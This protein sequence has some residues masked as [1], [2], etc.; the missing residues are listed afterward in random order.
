[1]AKRRKLTAPSAEDLQAMDAEFR[2]ETP[3]R[4]NKGSAPIAQVAADSAQLGSVDSA[5][6][7][8]DRLDA[9]RLRDAEKQGLIVT[10]I[11]TDKIHT[12]AMIRDRMVLHEEELLELQYSIAANGL[13]LPIEV[14]ADGDGYALLSGYRRLM[15]MR[16]L[17]EVNGHERHTTIK[18]F[19]RPATDTATSF[20]AMVEENEVR[21]NLSHFERG[22]IAVIAA[23][24]GAFGSTEEAVNVLFATASKSKRS[25]VRSFA[26]VFEMLGDMLS[27]ADGLTERRGLRLAGALRQG[28]E[29]QL[30]AALEAGQGGSCELEWE[31]ME[32]VIAAIEEGPRTAPKMGRPRTAPPVGWLGKDTLRLSS[33]VTLQKGRDSNGFVIRLTGKPVTSDLIDA[34]MEELRHLFEKP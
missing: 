34:A 2:S 17:A 3:A 6:T 10:E 19:I 20:A 13:R 11:P 27:F 7:R 14:Y 22:R 1:M 9:N 25:K 15:A 18:A 26:E 8:L 30:R 21:A 23:Q 32:P 29:N 33:G 12:N 31:A 24:E 16:N 28:C 4:P 5:Q